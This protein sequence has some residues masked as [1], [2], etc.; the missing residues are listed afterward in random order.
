MDAITPAHASAMCSSR[1]MAPSQRRRQDTPRLSREHEEPGMF[2]QG[3]AQA[4]G[5]AE[6]SLV[7]GN[8]DEAVGDA[9][10]IGPQRLSVLAHVSG[11]LVALRR[12]VGIEGR[13]PGA[14]LAG[15]QIEPAL[16]PPA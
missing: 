11:E 5:A 1:L 13:A 14:Y 16:V 2:V 4:P 10:R 7:E 15:L 12:A 8:P 6:A 3:R 9:R